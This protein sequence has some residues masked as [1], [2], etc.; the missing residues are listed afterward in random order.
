MVWEEK[1]RALGEEVGE[2]LLG[3]N[4]YNHGC[5]IHDSVS[6]LTFQNTILSQEHSFQN[7]LLYMI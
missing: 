1:S 5:L 3:G 2:E 7:V 4:K 6:S